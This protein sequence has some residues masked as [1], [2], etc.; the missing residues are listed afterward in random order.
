[1]FCYVTALTRSY[2]VFQRCMCSHSVFAF[3]QSPICFIVYQVN[4]CVR[5]SSGFMIDFVIFSRISFAAIEQ[6]VCLLNRDI[7]YSPIEQRKLNQSTEILSQ[8]SYLIGIVE[9]STQFV[10][11]IVV[12]YIYIFMV[13]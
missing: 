4:C 5:F 9:R 13:L 2:V 3:T 8:T 1:M 6:V 10:S 7:Q 11:Q 12:K